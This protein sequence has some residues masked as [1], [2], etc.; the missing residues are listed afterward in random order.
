MPLPS[1]PPVETLV[2]G[3]FRVLVVCTGNVCRSPLAAAV[4]RKHLEPCGTDVVVAS[5][6][7]QALEGRPIDPPV[8]AEAARL[9]VDVAGHRGRP[10]VAAEAAAADL[11]IVATRR[12]RALA[13]ERAPSI[14]RRAFTL[15]ELDAVLAQLDADDVGVDVEATPRERLSGVVRAANRGRGPAVRGVAIDLPDPYRGSPTLHR[16]VADLVDASAT[17]IAERSLLLAGI[18]HPRGAEDVS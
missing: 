18:C 9:G 7:L 15:L 11:V 8:A 1:S 12:Q 16:G 2:D 3:P 4:L 10:F 14:V 6:G 13:V 17:R 5:A